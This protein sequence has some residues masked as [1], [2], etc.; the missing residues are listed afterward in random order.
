MT[1]ID[2]VKK[3]IDI[4]IAVDDNHPST[5]YEDY[6]EFVEDRKGHDFRY[7][8]NYDKILNELGWMPNTSFQG[9]LMTTYMYYKNMIK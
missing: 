3:L 7:S 6:I 4:H 2:I 1:N 5:N 8:I 9:G